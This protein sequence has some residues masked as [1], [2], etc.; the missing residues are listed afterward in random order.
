[1]TDRKILYLPI[2]TVN[3]ELDAKILLALEAI[4]NQYHVIIG[5]RMFT[6]R[7]LRKVGAGH[8]LSKDKIKNKKENLVKKN[9]MYYLLDEE[10]LVSNKD[11]NFLN[12][13]PTNIKDFHDIVFF[14]GNQQKRL[15]ES[16]FPK[17][18]NIFFLTGNPRIDLLKKEIQDTLTKPNKAP[19]KYILINTNFSAGN[20]NSSDKELIEMIKEKFVR[21]SQ[22]KWN[23]KNEND[24]VDKINYYKLLFKEYVSMIQ[25]LSERFPSL[26]FIVRPHPSEN[27]KTWKNELNSLNNVIITREENVHKWIKYSLGVIHTGC[28]TGIE[29]YVSNIPVIQYN[30][31]ENKNIEPKLPN[32]ISY[33]VTK[34]D[35]L[36]NVVSKLQTGKH[37]FKINKANRNLFNEYLFIDKKFSSELIIERMNSLTNENNTELKVK[38]KIKIDIKYRT[39]FFIQ[40]MIVL[41]V[42][43]LKINKSAIL[44]SGKDYFSKYPKVS[45]KD[46]KV[47]L[48]KLNSL[49]RFNINNIKIHK[50]A[51]STFELYLD[52]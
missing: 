41:M 7:I 21:F 28:T 2:E 3:R 5:R 43:L 33:K 16:R 8:Y 42:G 1:M 26:N 29:S 46:L 10:G 35:R 27:L 40:Y 13:L 49:N 22:K 38:E 51:E 52:D 6:E 45:K 39:Q 25:K 24:L 50:V 36:V 48:E 14:W 4:K 11:E 9:V 20:N 44:N 15:F 47:R 19:E 23:Q 34:L 31:I 12:N 17:L 32:I 30:P 37:E 18:K